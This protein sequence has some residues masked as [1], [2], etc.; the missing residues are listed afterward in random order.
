MPKRQ[1]G[2]K[3]THEDNHL[4]HP[5]RLVDVHRLVLHPDKQDR[6]QEAIVADRGGG[7]H[8][9]EE[10]LPELR[11]KKHDADDRV[12]GDAEAD[13]H[14]DVVDVENLRQV[15]QRGHRFVI[16]FVVKVTFVSGHPFVSKLFQL[17]QQNKVHLEAT[18]SD[19]NGFLPQFGQR[20]NGENIC[21]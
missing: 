19:G 20:G 9:R 2:E 18:C 3:V 4:T 6:K 17:T 8:V 13:Y 12:E 14:R 10:L 15:N 7:K 5:R 21:N 1:E 16:R 11:P